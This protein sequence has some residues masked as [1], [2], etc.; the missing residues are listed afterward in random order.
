MSRARAIASR[1][2]TRRGATLVLV[3]ACL[4][5]A[6][7]MATT[8]LRGGMAARRRL[9]AEH[10]ARQVDCL[11]DAAAQRIAARVAAAASADLDGTRA[12]P[13]TES[14]KLSAAELGVTGLGA[15]GMGTTDPAAADGPVARLTLRAE[16]R[17]DGRWQADLVAEYPLAGP[18]PVRRSR[19][20]VLTPPAGAAPSP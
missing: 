18:M 2:P 10:H 12:A 19:S 4:A 8:M 6:A 17:A 14:L 1:R 11:L 16:P 5:V 15:I 13:W 7:V 9:R 20:F 3:L